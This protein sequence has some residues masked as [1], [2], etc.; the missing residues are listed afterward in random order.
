MDADQPDRPLSRLARSARHAPHARRASP[1]DERARTAYHEAGHVVVALICAAPVRIRSVTIAESG[2][3]AGA[4]SVQSDEWFDAQRA[5]ALA[6]VLVAGFESEAII[7]GRPAP[8]H[9]RTDLTQAR[10]LFGLVGEWIGAPATVV[11]EFV[12]RSAR[13]ILRQRW[14]AVDSLA[15]TLLRHTTVD[16]QTARAIVTRGMPAL[17]PPIIRPR[18]GVPPPRNGPPPARGRR[19]RSS[20]A[21]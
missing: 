2:P 15:H 5:A 4:L 7:L 16:G 11:G 21:G 12:H 3:Y 19:S 17:P 9:A 1:T 10:D 18:G 20:R 14:S 8:E 13:S 6:A